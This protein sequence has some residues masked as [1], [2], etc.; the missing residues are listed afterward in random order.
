MVVSSNQVRTRTITLSCLAMQF[1]KARGRLIR[2]LVVLCA[3]GVAGLSTAC[4]SSAPQVGDLRNYPLFGG[5][6]YPWARCSTVAE[7]FRRSME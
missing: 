4:T 5:R 2:G 7:T 1:K 3:L 6:G